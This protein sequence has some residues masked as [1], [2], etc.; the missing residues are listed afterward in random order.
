M[1]AGSQAQTPS[2]DLTVRSGSA[3]AHQPSTAIKRFRQPSMDGFLDRPMAVQEQQELNRHLIRAIVSSGSALSWV[4]DREVRA[5]FQHLRPMYKLPH[6]RQLT[7]L[8]EA[9]SMPH[10][11][12]WHSS[13]SRHACRLPF[14]YLLTC[15]VRS[16]MQ[17]CSGML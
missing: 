10:D 12:C 16:I 6:R 15:P 11:V 5:L 14:L 13:L 4:D 1:E 7:D 8:L 3:S 9:V 17:L 2:D